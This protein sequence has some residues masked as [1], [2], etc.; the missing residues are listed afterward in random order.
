MLDPKRCSDH[1]NLL[2]SVRA[3]KFF[4]D[5][6]EVEH[7]TFHALR[8]SKSVFDQFRWYLVSFKSVESTVI[9]QNFIEINIFKIPFK[10]SQTKH[11]LFCYNVTTM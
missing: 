4:G 6:V 8:S 3:T 10:F 2:N 1:T 5:A 11:H 9:R 7:E